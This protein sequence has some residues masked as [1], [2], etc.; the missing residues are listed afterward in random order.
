MSQKFNHQFYYS[1]VQVQARQPR[2]ALNQL[3]EELASWEPAQIGPIGS[4]G[5]Q[6][7]CRVPLSCRQAVLKT[8]AATQC[9]FRGAA[10]LLPP[11]PPG[12]SCIERTEQA[13]RHLRLIRERGRARA[14]SAQRLAGRPR[15]G[16][17]PGERW[18]MAR[19]TCL[20]T[21]TTGAAAAGA[22]QRAC[23]PSP[24]HTNLGAWVSRRTWALRVA[25]K[26]Q[27]RGLAA[28]WRPRHF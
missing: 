6:A 19:A 13:A 17:W 14:A 7:D 21:M 8:R 25:S 16:R 10:Q 3:R 27:R 11:S 26:A 24:P 4:G 23:A 20:E 28:R 2:R 1:I 9:S 12:N 5:Q 22:S 15:L 18:T